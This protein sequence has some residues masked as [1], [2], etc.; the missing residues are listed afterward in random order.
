VRDDHR[1]TQGLP[2]E[3]VQLWVPSGRYCAK[4]TLALHAGLRSSEALVLGESDLDPSRGAPTIAHRLTP[5]P[6][7]SADVREDPAKGGR[8]RVRIALLA[9]PDVVAR[10]DHRLGPKSLR[11]G[12]RGAIGERAL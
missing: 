3:F 2:R 9:K 5:V 10:E 6:G 11:Q 4:Q 7:R 8:E 12:Q 1:E